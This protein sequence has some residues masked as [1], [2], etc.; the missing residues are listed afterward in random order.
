MAASVGGQADGQAG[1]TPLT[2]DIVF[3]QRA[4]YEDWVP[5]SN[6]YIAAIHTFVRGFDFP[7]D[8]QSPADFFPHARALYSMLINSGAYACGNKPMQSSEFQATVPHDGRVVIE[9]CPDVN[10]RPAAYRV[11]VESRYPRTELELVRMRDVSCVRDKAVHAA[12]MREYQ[13]ERRELR[14]AHEEAMKEFKKKVSLYKKECEK[15]DKIRAQAAK[16][17]ARMEKNAAGKRKKRKRRAPPAAQ[18]PRKKARMEGGIEFEGSNDDQEAEAEE[19]EPEPEPEPE[20]EASEGGDAMDLDEE[21]AAAA[22]EEEE[23]GEPPVYS[24]RAYRRAVET[25]K[26]PPVVGEV[27]KATERLAYLNDLVDQQRFVLPESMIGRIL[28]MHHY[29]SI[30]VADKFER[31]S[32]KDS[33]LIF[34]KNKPKKK[35]RA[36]KYLETLQ[37]GRRYD[38][39]FL[40][41]GGRVLAVE[42]ETADGIASETYIKKMAELLTVDMAFDLG[43]A[44]RYAN[45]ESSMLHSSLSLLYYYDDI[46]AVDPKKFDLPSFTRY[47]DLELVKVVRRSCTFAETLM[48]A[49]LPFVGTS[50]ADNLLY[51]SDVAHLVDRR[52][53]V[54]IALRRY[55]LDDG[56]ENPVTAFCLAEHV[57]LLRKALISLDKNASVDQILQDRENEGDGGGQ[58]PFEDDAS[59]VEWFNSNAMSTCRRLDAINAHYATCKYPRLLSPWTLTEKELD[60]IARGPLSRGI[61]LHPHL[62]VLL[63]N[64][65]IAADTSA[66]RRADGTFIA[67]YDCIQEEEEENA[68]EDKLYTECLKYMGTVGDAGSVNPE[69]VKL[70]DQ[71]KLRVIALGK[72]AELEAERENMTDEEYVAARERLSR[73]ISK[74][75]LKLFWAMKCESDALIA[76]RGALARI[77]TRRSN[78]RFGP[79]ANVNN[80]SFQTFMS[81]FVTMH[82]VPFKVAPRAQQTVLLLAIACKSHA[83]LP[84]LKASVPLPNVAILGDKESSK[85]FAANL[86]SL[87]HLEGSV[88]NADNIS[89]QAFISGKNISTMRYYILTTT[90][91]RS[92]PFD[93][94]TA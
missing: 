18:P 88:I 14:T 81:W 9:T 52:K 58:L 20:G 87:I 85:S 13:S 78:L 39:A 41:F 2:P 40:P 65:P 55:S 16:K 67:A 1:K 36:Y 11:I 5:N 91:P 77:L 6:L 73:E 60:R 37:W 49:P 92:R 53:Q 75:S 90:Y 31:M 68:E 30:G 57:A 62:S 89:T 93:H 23:E 86:M 19:P 70:S 71:L 50:F 56:A 64:S 51:T 12:Q 24:M 94:R 35:H 8:A 15:E 69:I 79:V 25:G 66:R 42:D 32:A 76:V 26:Y 46:E 34:G 59:L 84:D 29:E 72:Y 47:P 22:D 61:V 74:R 82:V 38:D 48:S 7:E 63:L 28:L 54:I 4:T 44:K 45:R 21:G 80:N 10:G 17:K 83:R 3:A 27:P 33:N 43:A